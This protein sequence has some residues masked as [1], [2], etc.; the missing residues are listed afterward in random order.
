MPNKILDLDMGNSR[1]KW[2]LSTGQSG[3]SRNDAL[4]KF[5]ENDF[6]VLDRIRVSCV[7]NEKIQ[8]QVVSFLAEKY[9][10]KPEIAISKSFCSGLRNNYENPKFLG[11]DRWLACLS[12]WNVSNR[13]AVLIID[14]GSALTI[15][16][17]NDQSECLGGFISPG[18]EMMQKALVGNT[19]KI[20]C[21]IDARFYAG[22]RLPTN[23]QEAV[24][25]GA[26]LAVLAVVERAV[27][28]FLQQWPAGHICF[29]GGTGMA[30][31]QAI[32]MTEAYY[33][34]LV[35]D[36]LAIALP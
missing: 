31:A 21:D 14:A 30:L 2:R 11:V 8:K 35:L 7:S 34:E 9:L 27:R 3:V 23:T 18:L 13:K 25:G 16:T 22:D 28:I 24:Q 32:G 17:M 20:D 1:I 36:G 4:G 12:A 26:C 5:F 15:D 6:G 19:G 10:C 33:P 29:T